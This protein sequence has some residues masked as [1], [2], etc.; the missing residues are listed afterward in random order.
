MSQT[1]L[2][3]AESIEIVKAVNNKPRPKTGRGGTKNFP[4]ARFT[5][6]TDEDRALVKQLLTEV[7]AAYKQPRVRSDEELADRLDQYFKYCGETGIIPTVEE[8]ALYT[9]YTSSTLWDWES[10]KNHGFSDF[11]SGIIK[12]AKEFLKSFDAKL[13]IAGKM[14]FLAYCF[15]AKNYYGMSDKQE[16]VLA[17]AHPYGE[18]KS[19]AQIQAEYEALPDDS[20]AALPGD[21][22]DDSV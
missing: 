13:V 4:N 6:E 18:Q 3:Q 11:T 19:L 10:G 21:S 17:P 12:K 5:P 8:M 1:T 22:L 2:T 9:G 14:N 15:R 7:H 20:M 16:V